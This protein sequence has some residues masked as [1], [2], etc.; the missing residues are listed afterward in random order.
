MA[1]LIETCCVIYGNED[2]LSRF[3]ASPAET[4]RF[5]DGEAVVSGE[6][7]AGLT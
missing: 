5:S 4:S 2:G 3:S 6:M 7:N 1:N